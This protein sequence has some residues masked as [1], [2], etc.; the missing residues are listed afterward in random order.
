MDR[1][2]RRLLAT[3]VLLG[4]VGAALA[5]RHPSPQEDPP[6]GGDR[7]V[8]RKLVGTPGVAA[9]RPGPALPVPATLSPPPPPA[10]PAVPPPA[11]VAAARPTT[12]GP[13]NTGLP[14]PPLAAAYPRSESDAVGPGQLVSGGAAEGRLVETAGRK[15]RV[16]DGDTL[17]RL[18]DR[19]LGSAA[20]AGEI[21]EAN[22]AVLASPQLLPIG[23]ELVIPPRRA[24]R[25]PAIDTIQ[26]GGLEPIP[27]AR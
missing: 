22:R 4:G 20:L 7:P 6:G 14:P 21:Y 12:L 3:G 23:A 8:F 17:E 9:P 2:L 18:A 25:L 5:F 19:Y 11:E 16:V 1:G 15:H 27:P 13:M 24:V 26:A 10:P